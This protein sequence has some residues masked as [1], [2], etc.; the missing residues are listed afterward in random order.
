MHCRHTFYLNIYTIY[1]RASH[2]WVWLTEF[3]KN[4]NSV[5]KKTIQLLQKFRDKRH[6]VCGVFWPHPIHYHSMV[7]FR[8]SCR[9]LILLH[10]FIITAIYIYIV[11]KHRHHSLRG[12]I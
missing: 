10:N 8:I 11:L 3:H 12:E 4:T 6:F 1:G 5:Q 2:F 7:N 9:K